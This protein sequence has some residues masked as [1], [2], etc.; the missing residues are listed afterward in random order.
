MNGLSKIFTPSGEK[1]YVLFEEIADNIESMGKLFYETVNTES[2]DAHKAI[3]DKIEQL[4]KDNDV[5]THRLFIEL[6]KT[7][8]TPFDREDIH[9]M[10]SALDDIADNVWSTT[11]HMYYFRI[12]LVSDL[13]TQIAHN[14]IE[15]TELL[16]KIMVGL[17]NRRELTALTT[18][19]SDMRGIT[20]DADLAISNAVFNLLNEPHNDIDLI[21]LNDHYDILQQMN[22]KCADVINVV[23]GIV[24]KYA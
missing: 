12:N 5:I 3:L 1:F 23:E 8:I 4:E 13:S 19:L 15:F 16:S 24:I 22:N 10:A 14:L 11:K 21:K 2:R 18:I 20:S 7:Y 6:G 9:Y 17:R